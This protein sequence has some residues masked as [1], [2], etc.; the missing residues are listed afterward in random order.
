MIP[1]WGAS[2][3]TEVTVLCLIIESVGKR[4]RTLLNDQFFIKK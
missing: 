1:L 3:G 2:Q 4:S